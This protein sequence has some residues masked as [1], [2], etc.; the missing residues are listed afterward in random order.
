MKRRY[1]LKISRGD[2]PKTIEE[3]FILYIDI[4]YNFSMSYSY[5]FIY[6]YRYHIEYMKRV[7]KLYTSYLFGITVK[8]N[9]CFSV[10]RPAAQPLHEVLV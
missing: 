5:L 7:E 1:N 10:S 3:Y 9:K 8:E 6:L 2:P 4:E